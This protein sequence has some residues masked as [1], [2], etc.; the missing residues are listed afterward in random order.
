M[1]KRNKFLYSFYNLSR[2]LVLPLLK[3]RTSVKFKNK[4]SLK[5]T[6]HNDEL[7]LK[8]QITRNCFVNDVRKF[9]SISPMNFKRKWFSFYF[10]LVRFLRHY[11]S[12]RPSFGTQLSD[13][14]LPLL[15]NLF[16]F[17]LCVII[18]RNER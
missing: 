2:V 18:P 12:D 3:K 15:I 4:N 9:Y 7:S 1:F 16:F 14:L 13:T 10:K 17:K 8:S 6:P 11:I 5:R